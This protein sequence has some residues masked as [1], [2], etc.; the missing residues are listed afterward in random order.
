[1][2]TDTAA[3]RY[4]AYHNAKDAPDRLDYGAMTRV[5]TGLISCSRR[6]G[7]EMKDENIF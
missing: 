1:M 3:Y 6:V 4:N 5:T 2:V 7:W